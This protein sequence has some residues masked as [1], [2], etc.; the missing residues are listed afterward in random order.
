MKPT[1]EELEKQLSLTK[2]ELF[3]TKED[4]SHNKEELNQTKE[5]LANLQ[6]LFKKALEEI[7]KLRERLNLNS[8]NSSKPPSTDQKANTSSKLPK[9]RKKRKGISRA[10]FPPDRVDKHIECARKNCPYCGSA[11]IQPSNLL[12]EIL[13]QV[14]LPNVRAIVT[15]YLLLKYHCKSCGENSKAELP[16]G[17]PHSSFGPKLMALMSTL[18]GV[19][20][21]AK[22]E[23]IQLIKDIYDIDIG[24]GSVSNIE[25]RVSNA[26]DLVCQKIHNFVIESSFCKHFDETGWRD[27]GKRHFVWLA[28]CE[29]AAYYMI[30]RSRSAEAFRKLL[31]R[32]PQDLTAVTDRYAVYNVIK[33]HQYCL[34]HLIRE[35]RKYSE[36]DGP[37]KRIGKALYKWLS[38]ACQIHRDY[39]EGKITLCRRNARLKNCKGKVEEWLFDGMAN[40]SEKL[41]KLCENL[42]DN[43]ENIWMFTKIAGMEPTNNLGER[44]MRK[45]VI[46]RKKSYGTRSNRGK[47]FVERITTVAQ[48]LKRQ[49]KNVLNFIEETLKNFYRKDKPP[50]ISESLGF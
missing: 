43:F 50:L 3:H 12:P 45:L 47:K 9:E 29:H 7:A 38:K 22:R 30:D 46:W 11:S 49:G 19:F 2:E 34:A 5:V 37:D 40:G 4:L 24:L 15:E 14:E 21:L 42:L 8:N 33:R 6:I 32:D 13:Q 35:F 48:T 18:T 39:R 10:A 36:R 28:S 16:E 20:H 31:G 25:E 26:L 23:A 41:Y 44:D 27:C 1:Y 17:I